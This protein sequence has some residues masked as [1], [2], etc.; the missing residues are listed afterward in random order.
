MN[1]QEVMRFIGSLSLAGLILNTS[2]VILNISWGAILISNVALV[3]LYGISEYREQKRLKEEG[4]PS[5]DER[6]VNK[7]KSYFTICITSFI[8]LFIMYLCVNKY[9]DRQ[10]VHENE[11]LYI[12]IFGLL[13]S[14][15]STSVLAT[16]NR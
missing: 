3:I 10:A 12:A 6:V 15:A 4:V 5:I 7:I 2:L 14:M 1:K 8:F 16:R 9:L 11:L 13:I